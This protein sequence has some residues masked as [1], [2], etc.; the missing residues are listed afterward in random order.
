MFEAARANGVEVATAGF[1][2]QALTLPD[3]P[4]FLVGYTV[5]KRVGNAVARNRVKRRLRALVRLLI[6]TRAKSG[7]AYVFIGR[8]SAIDRPYEKLEADFKYAFH[9]LVEG[10]KNV[11]GVKDGRKK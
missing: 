8:K 10:V 11:E 9:K 7:M 1:I 2:V 3:E 4:H 5:S 6:P